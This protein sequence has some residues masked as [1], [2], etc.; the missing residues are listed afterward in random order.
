MFCS[1]DGCGAV[2]DDN[3]DDGVLEDCVEEDMEPCGGGD[4]K[5]VMYI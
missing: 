3:D 1:G 2:A 5:Y 4:F